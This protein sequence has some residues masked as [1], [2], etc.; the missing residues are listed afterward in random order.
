MF[1]PF[2]DGTIPTDNPHL[3]TI[4]TET[5][6]IVQASLEHAIAANKAAG[7]GDSEGRFKAAQYCAIVSLALAMAY[8]EFTP[9]SIGELL[10]EVA[11]IRGKVNGCKCVV[12]GLTF[13]LEG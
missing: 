3:D 8:R 1:A 6:D 13:D 11:E 2:F 12:A 7:V 4:P 5:L 9:A 10:S